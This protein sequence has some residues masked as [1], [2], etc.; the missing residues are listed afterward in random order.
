METKKV[1]ILVDMQIDGIAYKC[2]DVVNLDADKAKSLNK[3]GVVDISS[4]AVKYC[5][6]EMGAEII[7]HEKPQ[8][9]PAPPSPDPV[10]GDT[11]PAGPV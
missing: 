6:E 4:A 3:E 11:A 9:E 2:N 7:D 8:A 10:D 5:V 1:R